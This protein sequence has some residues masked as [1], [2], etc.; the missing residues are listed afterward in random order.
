MSGSAL[1]DL[2]K[3]TAAPRPSDPEPWSAS[4]K[5]TFHRNDEYSLDEISSND[6]KRYPPVSQP[7]LIV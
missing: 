1:L 6:K 4:N 2:L 7:T 3:E 5:R